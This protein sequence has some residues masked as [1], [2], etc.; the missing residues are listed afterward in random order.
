MVLLAMG[1]DQ[2]A[3]ARRCQALGVGVNLDPVEVTPGDV[4]DAVESVLANPGYRKVARRLQG[5]IAAMPEPATT[6]PLLRQLA[7]TVP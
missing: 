6:V 7:D 3:N 5:E 1:A 4:R 2:P